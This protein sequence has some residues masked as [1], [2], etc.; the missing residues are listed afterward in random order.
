MF[1]AVLLDVTQ[2][3]FIR[4]IV[5]YAG[6]WLSFLVGIYFLVQRRLGF[7]KELLGTFL[8]TGGV[9]LIPL[10]IKEHLNLAVI[11]L[12]VQFAITALINLLLFS[13]D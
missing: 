3:Y 4:S 1:F 5:F 8:Y 11:F 7:L 2:I 13:L 6:L 10:S 9:L 12:I